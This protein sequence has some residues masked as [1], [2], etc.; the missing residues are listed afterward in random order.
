MPTLDDGSGG[1]SPPRQVLLSWS[2]GKDA[3]WTLH[4]LRQAPGIEVVGLLSTLT[5]DDGRASLQGIRS[6]VLRAQAEACRLPLLE[7]SIPAAADNARYEAAIAQALDAARERWPGIAR[8]AFG[9]LF[10]ADI[11]HWREALCTRL[12]WTPLFP[13]YGSDTRALAR[14]MLAGGL[15][16]RLCCVDTTQL[17]AGFAG[18]PFDAALLDA[19]PAGIDPCGERGEFHTCVHAG[20]MFDHALALEQGDTA[21]RDARFAV[22]DYLLAPAL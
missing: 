8:L 14:E 19:L 9:D 13:L 18:R 3:A 2:G 10:L 21:L 20:P 22:T 1:R 4:R 12:G 11:R 6:E 5:A 15:Q 16:A 7:A 17:D